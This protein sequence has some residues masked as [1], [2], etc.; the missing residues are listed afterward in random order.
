VSAVLCVVL[1]IVLGVLASG[2]AILQRK[3]SAKLNKSLFRMIESA[4]RL[5]W[6]AGMRFKL[7]T[8]VG[9]HQCIAAAPSVFDVTAPPGLE[10]YTKW[11]NLIEFPADFGVHIVIPGTCFGSYRTRLLI[12]SV[13]PVALL[14]LVAA[15]LIARELA[16]DHR[17]R[18]RSSVVTSR[19]HG[20]AVRSGLERTLPL[21]LVLTFLLVPS[22]ATRVF[23]TFLCDPFLYNSQAGETRRYLHDDLSLSCSSSEYGATRNIALGMLVLWPMGE[24]GRD[25]LGAASPFGC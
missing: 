1:I 23:K 14:S 3:C 19:S 24:S 8:I 15:C 13:W 2:S 25:K 21:T 10:E 9:L 6:K 16:R 20:A 17:N 7:K 22:T 18:D 11:V 12:L 4:Q 5:W